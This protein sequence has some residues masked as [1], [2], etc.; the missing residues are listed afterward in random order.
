[1]DRLI[2]TAVGLI[3]G[4]ILVFALYVINYGHI[5]P[6]EGFDGGALI[7]AVLVL[8]IIVY[9]KQEVRKRLN[10]SIVLTISAISGLLLILV[11]L[12]GLVS[13]GKVLFYNFIPQGNI[14]NLFS[15]GIVMICNIILGILVGASLYLLF[16]YLVI[17]R[18]DK[19]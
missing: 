14:H 5:L 11:G 7:A 16:G 1:M 6:G 13:K 18:R 4:P 2:K 3:I 8:C 12:I 15:S 17:Y 19:E 9:G 10:L